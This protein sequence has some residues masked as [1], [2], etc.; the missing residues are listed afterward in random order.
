MATGAT[1]HIDS[2]TADVFIGEVWSKKAQIA[3]E[4]A[5]VFV[6]LFNSDYKEDLT[7]GDTVFVPSIG[8]LT[9]TNKSVSANAATLYET[10]TETRSTILVQTWDY[11]A[12]AIETYTKLKTNQDLLARYAPKQGYALAIMIDDILAGLVD[13]FGTAAIGTLGA[14]LSY[15]DWL[16]GAQNLDDANAPTEDRAAVVSPRVKRYCMNLDQ[17]INKDY[18]TLQ[19]SADAGMKTP[20]GFFGTW[21]DIPFYMTTNV[22]GSNAAGHDN[23]MWQKEAVAVVV[24]KTPTFYP[25]F[26]D[27]DYFAIKVVGEQVSGSLEMRDDHGVFMRS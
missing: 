23:G 22:E 6:P 7:F 10:I 1:E 8:N 27:P 15:D 20:R 24:Q 4:Q 25:P 18:E 21:M 16:Q 26:F 19:G 17:F 14:P 12:L 3:R 9:G 2:V 11:H 13:D 5:L